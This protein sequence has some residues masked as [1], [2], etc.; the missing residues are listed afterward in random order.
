MSR[1]KDSRRVGSRK[2]GILNR[3]ADRLHQQG[4]LSEDLG[5]VKRHTMQI[6]GS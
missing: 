5:K 3:V 1:E 2:V 6:P 4:H